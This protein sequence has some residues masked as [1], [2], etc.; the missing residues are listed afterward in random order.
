VT[1]VLAPPQP[2]IVLLLGFAS[3]VDEYAKTLSN[4]IDEV[5][6]TSEDLGTVAL[7]RPSSLLKNSPGGPFLGAAASARD[8]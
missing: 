7:P 5:R 1:L 2:L 8:V 3:L 6:R 4:P